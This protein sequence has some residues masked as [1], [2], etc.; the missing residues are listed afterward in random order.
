MQFV[1]LP[2]HSIRIGESSPKAQRQAGVVN[3]FPDV[4]LQVVV[5]QEKTK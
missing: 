4:F 1:S 2:F 3:R 5:K